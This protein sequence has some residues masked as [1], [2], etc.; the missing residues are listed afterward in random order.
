MKKANLLL[1]SVSFF[2][3][4]DSFSQTFLGTE[5][6]RKIES[7][8]WVEYSKESKRPTFVEFNTS[9]A[10]FRLAV[11]NPVE[12]MKEAL[13]LRAEDNLV[14]IKKESD[15]IG[16]VHTKYQQTY[17]GVDVQGGQYIAH[18]KGGKLDCISGVF[19]DINEL[20]VTPSLTEAGALAKAL[21]FVG[22]TKYKWENKEELA[23]MRAAFEDP[24]FNYDPKGKLVIYPKNNVLGE[25]AD[26][27]LAY[28][29]N[30]YAE[31]PV[32][33]RANIYVDAKTGEIV[34][35]EE[36]IH[37]ADVEGTA[38][39]KYS[40]TQ[41]IMVTQKSTS[42]YVLQ[43][44]G[45]GKGIATYNAKNASESSQSYAN[46]DFTDADNN[47]NNVN[48]QMDEVATDAHWATEMTYDYFFKIHGRNSIDGNGFKLINYV[49]VGNSWFNASW[50]G[51]FMMYGDGQ[52]KPLTT[53]DI[54]GHEMA[55]GLTS[56][57]ADLVYQGESGAL[58]ESFS[59]IFGNMT[60]YT[61]RPTDNSW[62]MG[63]DIGAIRD[64]K[65]PNNYKNPDTYNGTHWASTASG[66]PDQGGVHINSGVQNKW[67]YI[68]S[69][70]E[71]GTNDKNT[72]YDVPGITR[73]KAAKIAFRNLTV[74]LST[75]SDYAAAR[76]NSLKAAKDL[77][78]ECSAEYVATG[79]AWNAVGVGEKITG[80]NVAPVADFS[81]N[82]TSS[83]DGVVQF[84]DKSSSAPT[85]WAW[86]FGDG[87]TS[88][89]Q[90]P[91]HTYT[92]SGKYTV[93][94][95]ATNANGKDEETKTS[96]VSVDLAASPTVKSAERCGPGKVDLSATGNNT[97]NWY[98]APTGGNVVNTG[99]TYSPDVTATT[100]YYVESSAAG[101][102][103]KV[104]PTDNSLTGGYFTA[105]SDRG[106]KFDV[107]APCI[108]KSVKVYAQGA[109]DRQ[110]DVLDNAGTVVK[111]KTVNVPDGESR[112]QLD[113]DLAVGTQYFIKIGGN[114][115]N[116]YRS[117][118][119][120]ATYPYTLS[121]LLSITETDVKDNNPGYYYFFYD[122]EVSTGGCSSARVEVVATIN[123]AVD[124]PEILENNDVLS[125]SIS[126]AGYTYKWFNDGAEI[127]GE[128][129]QSFT[130][131][132]NGNYTVVVTLGKCYNTSDVHSFFLGIKPNEMDKLVNVYPNPAKDALFVEAPIGSN[133]E[134]TI[135]VYSVIGKLVYTETYTNNGQ[136]RRINLGT[137]EANGV[138]FIKLQS[139][140][141][142]A[143]RKIV[144]DK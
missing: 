71:K 31:A 139:G 7:A 136:A 83:C 70:G 67:F 82:K 58:N 23:A 57:S 95:T 63:E 94:L 43:E 126:G 105:N 48:A 90:N 76:T 142:Q 21:A 91:S 69:M 87:G 12:A 25:N 108:L 110:I 140:A 135:N 104:G 39:T 109:G 99:A 73:E 42:S 13:M 60:E 5:A 34:G 46:T 10:N 6:A 35:R 86:D 88:T 40:G 111:T 20:S 4:F 68:L 112:V 65:T 92:A 121:G 114:L 32:E 115:I 18:Q 62:E 132:A 96:Y 19:M 15:E 85:S 50:N 26:Y 75:N 8:Q 117:N 11:A 33:S 113:F 55:H 81:V 143:V 41:K 64:M 54:G 72:A 84:T 102:A 78:G 45:R 134:I 118:D 56:N 16:F 103:Q 130:P 128:T 37:S 77:Y 49:H 27:R 133:K 93:K 144:I 47:W 14:S 119:G 1:V 36:L 100:K 24:N 66:A 28:K 30:I 123:P 61:A 17:K 122:W 127:A 38:Q 3:A 79:D 9:G 129:N 44:T 124:K 97:L 29:F 2:C 59:D 101:T 80:C 52:G 53:I 89:Q 131:K 138:Y 51:S 106:L 141:E 137:I 107:L 116:L 120:K 74:Y 125:A 98:T 22:A